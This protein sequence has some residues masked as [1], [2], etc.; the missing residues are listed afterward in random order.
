M[1]SMY[2]RFVLFLIRP[3]LER[4]RHEQRILSD[5]DAENIFGLRRI[6]R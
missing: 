1:K 5:R 3:A 6:G 4:W 2:A